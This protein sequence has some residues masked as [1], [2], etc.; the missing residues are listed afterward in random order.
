MSSEAA[1]S[2]LLLGKSAVVTGAAK[3]IGRATAELFAE[4]GARIV[5]SDIDGVG[6]DLLREE[7]DA[8]EAETERNVRLVGFSTHYN[9][10]FD[11]PAAERTNGRSVEQLAYLL[12]HILAAP[13]MLLATNR[14]SSGVGVRPRGNRVEITVDFTP[15]ATL[16]AATVSLEPT[17]FSASARA[18]E[19]AVSTP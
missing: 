3:G 1:P 11:L 12:T 19:R 17:S 18:S 15:D 13:V 10:S 5:A 6:L 8:W 7:L 14:R 9:V 2:G 4:E 16:M